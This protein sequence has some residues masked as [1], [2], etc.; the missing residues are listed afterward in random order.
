MDS[1]H[2]PA[3]KISHQE[4]QLGAEPSKVQ[5]TQPAPEQT[6]QLQQK[7]ALNTSLLKSTQ[8]AI[9]AKDESLSL[10]LN[11]AIERI[12]ESLA[13]VLGENA[14]QKAA[15]TGL[16]VSPEATAERIV[17]LSTSFYSAFKEQNAA[18]SEAESLE[19]FISTIGRGIDK[20]FEEARNILEGLKVLEEAVATNIDETYSLV[21]QKLSAFE[22]MITETISS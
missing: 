7:A 5:I 3:V 20:G 12:N 2:I 13:P 10:L 22:T 1:S 16:D 17:S 15:D 9:G 6:Q 4:K 18:S 11:T 21:Q 14:I 8:V 19:N